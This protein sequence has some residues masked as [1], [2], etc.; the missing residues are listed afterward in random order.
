MNADLIGPSSDGHDPDYRK[1]SIIILHLIMR[2]GRLCR[3]MTLEFTLMEVFDRDTDLAARLG[4][5]AM[6]KGDIGFIHLLV[7]KELH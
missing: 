6:H 4:H 1:I 7:F 3:Q 5:P 2:Q